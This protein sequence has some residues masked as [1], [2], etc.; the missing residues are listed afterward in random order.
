MVGLRILQVCHF[1]CLDMILWR[2]FLVLILKRVGCGIVHS[3]K[4]FTKLEPYNDL[5]E[6]NWCGYR[7]I[8]CLLRISRT[9][10]SGNLIFSISQTTDAASLN[11]SGQ[12]DRKI[13]QILLAITFKGH[14]TSCPWLI[15]YIL[16][17]IWSW[18]WEKRIIRKIII[19]VTWTFY[20]L[21]SWNLSSI[22][23][24]RKLQF[25]GHRIHTTT[26][27]TQE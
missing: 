9:W 18:N 6:D 10:N 22:N 21:Q 24:Q 7:S 15:S 3:A 13:G 23:Y 2:A 19:S 4:D 11:L 26:R 16:C 1:A 5:H 17:L 8:A 20:N 14:L 27:E 12:K 25:F